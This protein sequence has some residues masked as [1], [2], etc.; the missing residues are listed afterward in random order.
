MAHYRLYFLNTDHKIIQGFDMDCVDDQ[1][2][3]LEA[4]C[5]LIGDAPGE[6]WSGTRY[7]GQT[8]TQGS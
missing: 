3:Y 6:V 1:A 4:R 2:A 5:R 7:V 8:P